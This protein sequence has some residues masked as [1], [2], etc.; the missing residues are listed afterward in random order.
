MYRFIIGSPVAH[1]QLIID[2]SHHP[3]NNVA[4]HQGND[5]AKWLI[6]KMGGGIATHCY[7][8]DLAT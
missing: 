1:A 8:I 6:K 3:P 5:N 2:F 7:R 4:I